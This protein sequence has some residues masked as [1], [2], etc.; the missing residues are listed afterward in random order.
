MREKEQKGGILKTPTFFEVLSER[1]SLSRYLNSGV[2]LHVEAAT[3]NTEPQLEF[4]FRQYDLGRFLGFGCDQKCRER[5]REIFPF[6]SLHI[7]RRWRRNKNQSSTRPQPFV[8]L[9]TSAREK[10]K[11]PKTGN[12]KPKTAFVSIFVFPLLFL[13]FSLLVQCSCGTVDFLVLS[14]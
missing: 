9:F 12:R 1:R 10:K 6:S 14:D 3:I 7:R 13:P 11:N 5:K 8:A 4:A 2:V